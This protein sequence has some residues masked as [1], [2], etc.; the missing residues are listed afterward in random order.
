MKNL[1]RRKINKKQRLKLSSHWLPMRW[2]SSSSDPPNGSKSP[3]RE[4]QL[5]LSCFVTFKRA[6]VH[7]S[8]SGSSDNNQPCFI[9]IRGINLILIALD[10]PLDDQ[11]MAWSFLVFASVG[12]RHVP[13]GPPFIKINPRW[14]KSVWNFG[15][16]AARKRLNNGVLK[17]LA[18]VT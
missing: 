7:R 5:L 10:W 3:P 17:N 9:V 15:T 14:E 13:P 18:I 1:T 4:A 8:G 12:G 16:I 6:S 11:G 2:P